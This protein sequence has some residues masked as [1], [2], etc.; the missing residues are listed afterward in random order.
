[1]IDRISANL[2]FFADADQTCPLWTKCSKANKGMSSEFLHLAGKSHYSRKISDLVEI[3]EGN[4]EKCIE[5]EETDAGEGGEA[6]DAES[7]LERSRKGNPCR[8]YILN[9]FDQFLP[10]RCP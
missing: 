3:G 7:E 10:L 4:A 6:A 8:E 5:A 2:L 1:M 9:R